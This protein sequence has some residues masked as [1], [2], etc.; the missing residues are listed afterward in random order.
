MIKKIA[1]WAKQIVLGL[2]L[3]LGGPTVAMAQAPT[4]YTNAVYP[5]ITFTA[6]GQTSSVI[7]FGNNPS[8]NG[9]S[10]A[11]G[12]VSVTGTA[13][14]TATFSVLGSTDGGV[15]YNAL[16]VSPINSPSTVAT[17]TTVTVAGVYQVN[18]GGI[19]NV[20]FSTSGTFTATSISIVLTASPNGVIAR[21]GAAGSAVASVFSRTGAVVAQSGDYSVSQVT[22]AAPLA[23]PT[24]TG[25]PASVTPSTSDN[26]TKIATTAYVQ[27]NLSGLTGNGICSLANSQGV[28]AGVSYTNCYSGSTFDVRAN[29]AM[30]D[31]ENL[32]NGNTTGHVASEYEPQNVTQTAQITVGDGTHRVLW[33]LGAG[34]FDSVTLTGGTG[35]AVYQKSET[36]IVCVGV[37][38][39]GCEF[40][41][42][43]S[44]NTMYAL[45]GT[46]GNGYYRL[47]GVY[48]ANRGTGGTMASGYLGIINGGY[49]GSLWINDQ[50]YDGPTSNP[51]DTAVV[52]MT[53]VCCHAN[54]TND[55]FQSNFG[56]TAVDLENIGHGVNFQDDSFVTHGTT[57]SGNPNI[58]CHDSGP[59]TNSEASFTGKT[60]MEGQSATMT[61]PWI[62][63]NGCESLTFTGGLDAGIQGG[64]NTTAPLID[65]SSAF[66]TTLNIGNVAAFPATGG[67]TWTYPVT[68]VKQHNTTNDCGSPPCNVAVTDSVGNSPGYISRTMQ[69]NSGNM[70][71]ITT[72]AHPAISAFA[73]GNFAL[74]TAL[75]GGATQTLTPTATSTAVQIEYNI[76]SKPTGCSTFP[77]I[78][79]I[80]LSNSNAAIC[81]IAVSG[82]VFQAHGSCSSAAMPSGHTL[83]AAITTAAVGCGSNTGTA[84]I[85]LQYYQNTN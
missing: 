52:Q 9:G 29:S 5:A 37:Q 27:A 55:T 46:N 6:T 7:T 47:D 76:S 22:G 14:T 68:I 17:T 31:A 82:S 59:G 42:L 72:L 24:F 12:N 34:M 75:N 61:A 20:K 73:P 23:S 15:T 84:Y 62:Q 71:G 30:S 67:A 13:L 44:A 1:T 48:F 45:Y 77:S 43:G 50:W 40:A 33:T 36:S 21:A 39:Y 85:T 60:Y 4:P 16:N 74:S 70:G 8:G 35:Y 79:I 65:V 54:F 49:D 10:Y 38:N 41:N 28:Y 63:D 11:V 57:A 32:T 25:T 78:G 58:L 66:E 81:S 64:T 2:A 83:A 69:F 53:N 56:A 51:S 19:T 3:C 18:L 26:T 80:D